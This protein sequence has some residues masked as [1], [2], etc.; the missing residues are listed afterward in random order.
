MNKIDS[1]FHGKM[2]LKFPGRRTPI[3]LTPQGEKVGYLED[4]DEFEVIRETKYYFELANNKV[5]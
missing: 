5:S 3:R 2:R 1:A 4:G